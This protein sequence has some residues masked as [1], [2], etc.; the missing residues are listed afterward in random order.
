[1]GITHCG[2]FKPVVLRLHGPF[3]EATSRWTATGFYILF[4]LRFAPQ[5]MVI[6]LGEPMGFIPNILQ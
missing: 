1:M 2:F 5:D 6:M 3:G 4:Q